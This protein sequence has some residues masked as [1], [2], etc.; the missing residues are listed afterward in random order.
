[1]RIFKTKWFA[2]FVRREGIDDPSL[3]AAIERAEQGLIDADLGGASL[4]SALP[5]QDADDPAGIA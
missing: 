4:S 2:W 1:M 5:A 3:R